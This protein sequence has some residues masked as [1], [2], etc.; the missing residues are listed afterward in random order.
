[1][2]R[3]SDLAQRLP[4]VAALRRALD[5]TDY[6]ADESLATALFLAARMG[7]PILLEGE[8]GVGKTEAAKALAEA[9]ETP[10]LRLQCYEGLTSS[11]ALYEWN[12][13]RQLLAIRLAEARG[14]TLRDADLFSE[15][16]LLA[17]PL[18][19]ALDH[20][21]PRPAVLLI[22]EVDR[23]DD[24][25]EA[26]LFELLAESAVTIPELRTRRA[27]FPPVVVLTSNRTRDLH[28]ALKRRC[29]YHWINY[30]DTQRVAAIIRRRVPA[31]GELLAD[32]VARGVARLRGLDLAKTPGVAEAISWAEALGVLGAGT[33]DGAAAERTAG[34]V[35][36]YSEDLRT[37]RAAGFAGLVSDDG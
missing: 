14:E 10:L 9:L 18:L 36:K 24:E 19:A 13:P 37:A 15:E 16:Y 34:A 4:D 33:L 12:Y 26:F 20:P 2:T 31:A 25:F 28:D 11:E 29:L 22:D 3:S 6:L 21:G 7:Q 1:M 17:R 27:R 30:P 35:L 8:P 5:E 23:G 32:Q